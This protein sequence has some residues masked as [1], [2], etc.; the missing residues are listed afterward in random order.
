MAINNI[1]CIRM[2]FGLKERTSEIRKQL[3]TEILD[4]IAEKNFQKF[5]IKSNKSISK[6]WLPLMGIGHS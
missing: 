4:D 2:W 1:R 3:A 6:K 5:S